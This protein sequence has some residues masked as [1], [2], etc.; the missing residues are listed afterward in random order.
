M[1]RVETIT[2]M[3]NELNSLTYDEKKSKDENGLILKAF[4]ERIRTFALNTNAATYI[5][6]DIYRYDE[7]VMGFYWQQVKIKVLS[8]LKQMRDQAQI[9]QDA[10]ES[11]RH[12]LEL[13]QKQHLSQSIEGNHSVGIGLNQTH[14]AN[15]IK[16]NKVF[17]VHGHENE[18][19]LAVARSIEKLGFE[20]VILH[21]QPNEGRTIIE[22]F[23]SSSEVGFAVVLLSPDDFGYSKDDKPE[24]ANLRSR[25]NVILELGYFLGKLGRNHVVALFMPQ[26]NF[27]M[28]SDFSGVLYIPFDDAGRWQFDLVKELKACGYEVDANK[29]LI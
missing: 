13:L 18:M 2:D 15:T 7:S 4:I 23:E 29:L 5:G 11:D 9:F 12:Q 26:M 19:K 21:E 22:K 17:I 24:N 8:A 10:L 14:K 3:I 16:N 28:P 25:Q 20:A 6:S 27:E 1:T